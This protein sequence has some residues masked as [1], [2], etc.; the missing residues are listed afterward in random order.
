MQMK[1]WEEGRKERGRVRIK[2]GTE[3]IGS[4]KEK[5]EERKRGTREEWKY[6]WRKKRGKE[7]EKGKREEIKEKERKEEKKN[8]RNDQR[9]EKERQKKVM[10]EG[11]KEERV[12]NIFQCK[13]LSIFSPKLL[14]TNTQ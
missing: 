11:S 6:R 10:N 8:E 13:F 14:N 7:V 9:K 1:K 4:V 2:R 5:K 3:L 12:C